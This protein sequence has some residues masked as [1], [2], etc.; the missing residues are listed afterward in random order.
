[1]DALYTPEQMR[2]FAEA[3]ATTT[4]EEIAA[5]EQG[6]TELLAEARASREL[7]PAS[8]GTARLGSMTLKSESEGTKSPSQM[9]DERIT[10]GRLKKGS[11]SRRVRPSSRAGAVEVTR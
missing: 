6:W 5:V 10:P 11:T 7:D 8:R 9:I 4:E 1:M 2:R 3:R